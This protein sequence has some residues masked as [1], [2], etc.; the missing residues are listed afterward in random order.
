MRELAA[1][2]ELGKRV[3]PVSF[4]PADAL[5]ALRSHE[6]GAALYEGVM[7]FPVL[8]CENDGWLMAYRS[9][10][11]SLQKTKLDLTR[12]RQDEGSAIAA[13]LGSIQAC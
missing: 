6:G 7:A 9:V 4:V 5:G 10:L 1:A 3:L 13:F 8:E 12:W 2:I 11:R